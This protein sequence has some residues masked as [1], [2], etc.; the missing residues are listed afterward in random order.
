MGDTKTAKQEFESVLSQRQEIMSVFDIMRGKIT[1]LKKIY[2]ELI[3]SHTGDD[4]MFGMDALHFQN[5]LIE[6][7]YVHLRHNLTAIERRMYCEYYTLYTQIQRY[8]REELED[9]RLSEHAAFKRDFPVYK[10][11]GVATAYDVKTV[12]E[13]YAAIAACTMELETTVSARESVLKQDKQHSQM[14]LNIHALVYREEFALSMM[15]AR[16]R[17]F[18]DYLHTFFLQHTKYL[19]RLLL[20]AKLQMGIVNED[21]L[22]KQFSQGTTIAEVGVNDL[23]KGLT[24]PHA[25]RKVASPTNIEP[26]E[27]RRIRSYI[28]Y[29]GLPPESR[30]TLNGIIAAGGGSGS[31]EGDSDA[32]GVSQSSATDALAPLPQFKPQHTNVLSTLEESEYGS[33]CAEGPEE[34]HIPIGERVL[35]EG[36]TSLGTLRFYGPHKVNNGMRC[37]VELDEACG[38]NDGTV[39]GHT[40]FSCD[41]LHGVLVVPYKVS[42][43]VDSSDDEAET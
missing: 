12:I 3:G 28:D 42:A 30:V 5:E 19:N 15:R 17:M 6:K 29:E 9:K 26:G 7:D 18:Y 11:L 34:F 14:G 23:A 4:Y 2:G 37:G 25:S 33:Q 24:P 36:Y 13:I 1:T 43:A 35:V 16:L 31:E 32:D 8:V 41:P 22:L 21:I 20:K 27:E 40:Y 10:H 38:R 39:G